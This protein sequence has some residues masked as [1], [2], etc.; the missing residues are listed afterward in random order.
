MLYQRKSQEV[1]SDPVASYPGIAVLFPNYFGLYYPVV[2]RE[3]TEK[4][5]FLTLAN[6][7]IGHSAQFE[8]QICKI[9][10]LA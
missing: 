1:G 5:C 3:C 2:F 8:F 7:N 10:F 9:L 4:G 6:K